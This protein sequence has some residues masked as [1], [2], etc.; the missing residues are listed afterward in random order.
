MEFIM[1]IRNVNTSGI[2]VIKYSGWDSH[3][4]T[5]IEHI[6]FNNAVTSLLYIPHVQTHN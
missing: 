3:R 4:F 6:R 5:L 1:A 2:A